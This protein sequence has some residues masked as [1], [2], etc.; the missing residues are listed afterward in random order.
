M[1]LVSR[2]GEELVFELRQRERD[3]LGGI[4]R[5]Y[6]LLNADYHQV[7]RTGST[8]QIA[9]CEH[10]LCDAMAEQRSKNKKLVADFLTDKH[11]IE[12]KPGRYRLTFT[13]WQVEWLLQVLN[14]VRVGS[15]VILG[16][17]DPEKGDKVEISAGKLPYA[18]AMDLSGYFQMVLLEALA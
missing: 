11:W 18:G 4:L 2:Q 16:K 1:K 14:D 7:S 9:E 13:A 6:P 3:L 5:L 8:E 12:E 10:L 15:W 17:P